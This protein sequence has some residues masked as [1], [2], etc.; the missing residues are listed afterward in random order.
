MNDQLQISRG[1]PPLG[2]SGKR[3]AKHTGGGMGLFA[4]HGLPRTMAR[5][6]VWMLGN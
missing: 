3:G 2:R 1:H 6:L 4:V 5:I